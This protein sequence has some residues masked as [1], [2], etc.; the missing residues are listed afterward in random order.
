MY[1][2]TCSINNENSIFFLKFPENL[3]YEF[4]AENDE[5]AGE[6]QGGRTRRKTIDMLREISLKI[7]LTKVLSGYYHII[8]EIEKQRRKN[9]MKDKML[10]ITN[11]E[12]KL[13]ETLLDVA[14]NHIQKTK[15][16]MKVMPEQ[17][18][19]YEGIRVAGMEALLEFLDEYK[20]EM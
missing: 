20:D 5:L 10:S 19:Y 1:I 7:I 18:R 15:A 9:R 14:E 6:M 4:F 13:I 8:V 3:F 12:R 17:Q 2:I 16:E 11:A